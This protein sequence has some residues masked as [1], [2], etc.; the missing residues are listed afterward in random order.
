MDKTMRLSPMRRVATEDDQIKNTALKS[1]PSI[2]VN[3]YTLIFCFNNC[4]RCG[5]IVSGKSDKLA[6]MKKPNRDATSQIRLM[7]SFLPDHIGLSK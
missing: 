1:K 6:D 2:R 5:K 7:K 4:E 3:L